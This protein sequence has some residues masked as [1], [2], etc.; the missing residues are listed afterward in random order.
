[1]I[2]TGKTDLVIAIQLVLTSPVNGLAV[3]PDIR[4]GEA[5]AI[6]N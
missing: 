3:G 6:I 2:K 5:K 1:M 4:V